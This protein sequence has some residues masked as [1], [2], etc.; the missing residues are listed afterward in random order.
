[1]LRDFIS[2][3]ETKPLETNPGLGVGNGHAQSRDLVR[4]VPFLG[5]LRIFKCKSILDLGSGDGY[6]LRIAES[7]GYS[8]CYGVEADLSLFE[9]SK[10]NLNRSTL[11]NQFFSQVSSESF[12]RPIH[13]IYFFNPDHPVG[14]HDICSRLR[15]LNPK[16]F[17]TKN[18]AF[19]TDTRY[20][21]SLRLVCSTGSYRL[22]KPVGKID[23]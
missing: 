9:I 1:M 11:L 19:D 16:F 22:Y 2:H 18:H 21:L 6:V 13:I 3:P 5:L 15:K 14:M 4:L 23:K 10:A 12:D 20:Q 17:L 8:Y 7:L